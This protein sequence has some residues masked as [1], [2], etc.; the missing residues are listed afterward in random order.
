MTSTMLLAILTMYKLDKA[1]GV[2]NRTDAVRF[3]SALPV[4]VDLKWFAEGYW[5]DLIPQIVLVLRFAVF[6]CRFWPG[7]QD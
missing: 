1:T 7:G 5:E 6:L 4:T 3:G 2:C